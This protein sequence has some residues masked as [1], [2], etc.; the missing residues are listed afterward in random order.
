[1]RSRTLGQTSISVSEL[2][3]GTW[4]LSGDAYGPVTPSEATRVI[5]RARTLGI[6]LFETADSYAGGEMERK[7]GNA[8]SGD[9]EAVIVTKLGTDLDSVPARKRFD[10]EYLARAFDAS[11]QRLGRERIDGV[12]L[13]NP[14]ERVFTKVGQADGCEAAAFL[15]SLVTQGRLRA[16]GVSAGSVRVAE[17]ALDQGADLLSLSYSAFHQSDLLGVAARLREKAVGLI[18]HSVLSYGLLAGLWP[19]DKDFTPGDHRFERWTRDELRLRIRQLD[20]L[21]PV[22]GG[23]IPTLR[24][25]ALRFVLAEPLVSSALLGP[26]STLQLDQLVREG[27]LSGEAGAAREYL[28]KDKLKALAARLR[29][30]GIEA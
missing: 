10:R 22:V 27:Q 19:G 20:A 1:M 24:A 12:L 3:L 8:L 15:R 30:V 4:G 28:T 7:L 13:H 5:E 9:A 6:T 29:D 23:T 18:A 21:R 16:W 11:C 14:S 17:A 25:A 26:R 2:G